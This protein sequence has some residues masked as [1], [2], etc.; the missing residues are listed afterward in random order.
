MPKGISGANAMIS[1]GALEDIDAVIALHIQSTYESGSCFF[2]DGYSMAA[3]DSFEATIYGD[4]GHGAYPHDGVDPIFMLSS[5]LPNIYGIQ[6]R[7]INPLSPSVISIGE[8][9]GGA[10]PNV[11]PK[12]VY[13]QGTIRSFEEDVRQ[14]LWAEIERA[15]KL[16][17][18][19]GGSYD[20]T[21][22]KGY[23]SNFNNADVNG[24]LRNVAREM[25]GPDRV[26]DQPFGMG[27]E[28]FSYM[29]IEA[30]GAMFMLGGQVPN[31]GNHHTNNFDI[32][33]SVFP[34]GS[35][36]LAETARRFVM[37]KL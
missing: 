17:E 31:G 24:W 30:P 33:E 13:V 29:G 22:H 23:P 28:D 18:P 4:G 15:F 35:A 8:V 1:D 10:A 12:S 16:S 32:D 21:I 26:I 20:L 27:A 11:I 25:V 6:S 37:K 5:I 19:L 7:Y 34:L 9:R 3:V 36:I 14:K 2:W